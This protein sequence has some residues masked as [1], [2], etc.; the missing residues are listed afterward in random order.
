M[1]GMKANEPGAETNMPK[2]KSSVVPMPRFLDVPYDKKD[3]AKALGMKWH[4]FAKLWYI[5]K[6]KQRVG[7]P[8]PDK[9]V[10]QER[11][12][13]IQAQEQAE[14]VRLVECEKA[15]RKAALKSLRHRAIKADVERHRPTKQILDEGNARL[16]FLLANSP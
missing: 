16:D 5:P 7:F 15:A 9:Y 4:P 6:G 13:H 12:N 8:Y 11:W 3:N 1:A 2:K 14:V 10:N